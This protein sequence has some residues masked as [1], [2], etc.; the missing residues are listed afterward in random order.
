MATGDSHV[1]VKHD[2]EMYHETGTKEKRR[3]RSLTVSSAAPRR[4][5]PVV[6]VFAILR[7]AAK[8]GMDGAMNHSGN[9]IPFVASVNVLADR[10][11]GYSGDAV[12]SRRRA[13]LMILAGVLIGAVI[14]VCFF[15]ESLFAM[16]ARNLLA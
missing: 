14:D 10:R 4:R 5:E 2:A 13:W 16:L 15:D 8:C 3:D 1:G 11:N 6:R 12:G 7:D 9:H